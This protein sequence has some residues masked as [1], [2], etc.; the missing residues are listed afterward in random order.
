MDKIEKQKR[1]NY[2]D[3]GRDNFMAL[4]EYL[5][6]GLSDRDLGKAKG[7]VVSLYSNGGKV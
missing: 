3:L 6:S 1:A 7:G 2:F 5:Q 4:E